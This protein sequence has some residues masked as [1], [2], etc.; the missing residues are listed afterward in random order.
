M[1]RSNLPKYKGREKEYMREYN[2]LWWDQDDRRRKHHLKKYGLTPETYNK[3]VE[4]QEAKCKICGGSKRLCVDHNHSDGAVR[5]LLCKQCNSQLGW[6]ENR[7][8]TILNYLD[9]N[10]RQV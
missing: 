6:F 3:L 1:E 9:E 7:K 2:K 4:D 5:G 8:D 10:S